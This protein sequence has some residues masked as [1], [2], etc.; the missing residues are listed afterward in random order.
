MMPSSKYLF[1]FTGLP[2][3]V[4]LTGCGITKDDLGLSRRTPDAFA[5]RERAPLEIPDDYVLYPPKPGAPRP[6][7]QSPADQAAQIINQTSTSQKTTA[8]VKANAASAS[9]PTALERALLEKTG[10]E[11]ASDDIRAVVG[12]EK[13]QEVDIKKPTIKRLLNIGSSK[14]QGVVLNPKEEADRLKASGAA[15]LSPPAAVSK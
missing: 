12:A 1:L 5:V 15:V 10:A 7:E 8:G 2:L 6:Q 4:A 3:I 11:N 14:P 13:G 9:V